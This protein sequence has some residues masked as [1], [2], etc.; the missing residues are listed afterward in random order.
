MNFERL[1]T[2]VISKR[3]GKGT[4][5]DFQSAVLSISIYIRHSKERTL[6]SICEQTE[7]L[8][9]S[10]FSVNNFL[11]PSFCFELEANFYLPMIRFSAITWLFHY[12]VKNLNV[13]FVTLKHLVYLSN[14]H[15]LQQKYQNTRNTKYENTKIREMCSQ[16]S[17]FQG[18]HNW[19]I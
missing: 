3:M 16:K 14:Q 19:Q 7:G 9:W 17:S 10:H 11:V 12:F 4:N 1:W 13:Y 15:I 2:I 8:F 6:F 5:Y 18:L